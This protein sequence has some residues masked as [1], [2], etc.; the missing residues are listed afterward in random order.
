MARVDRHING[1]VKALDR[2]IERVASSVPEVILLMPVPGISSFS[3]LMDHAEI[4]EID[5]FDEGG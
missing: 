5:R 1:R 2:E 4:G 3:G